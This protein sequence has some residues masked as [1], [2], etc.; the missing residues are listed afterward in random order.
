MMHTYC[1]LTLCLL[2]QQD[3]TSMLQQWGCI[4]AAAGGCIHA[5]LWMNPPP[6][7]HGCTPPPIVDRMTDACENITYAAL[8]CNAV[9]NNG[10]GRKKRYV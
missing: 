10:H 2:L 4:H 7:Q 1:L 9:G 6:L 8:L 3:G 5:A